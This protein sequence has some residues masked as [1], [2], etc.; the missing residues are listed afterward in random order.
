MIRMAFDFTSA[1]CYLALQPTLDLSK[2][3][4]MPLELLPYQVAQGPPRLL[5]EDETIA[6]RHMR[7]R[8]EYRR[9][10][11]ARYADLRGIPLNADPRADSS[12]ALMATEAY[13]TDERNRFAS[14]VF[15]DFWSGKL[16]LSDRCALTQIMRDVEVTEFD[17]K[18][19]STEALLRT[20]E[21][22][23]QDNVFNVPTY[24]VDDQVFQGR[25]H[26]PMI[27][28]LLNDRQGT[29]PL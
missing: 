18:E 29:P 23:E 28:W 12:S 19:A 25:E 14:R 3:L 7:V 20:R 21:S 2:E 13:Q 1:Q 9:M 15:H 16:A 5:R 17:W 24:L 22:L 10:D 8:D 6:E 11:A 26:L 4:S 27:R